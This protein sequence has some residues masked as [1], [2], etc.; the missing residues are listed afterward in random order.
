M[1]RALPFTE[2]SLRRAISAAQKAGLQVT[3]IKP[4][5][6]L[7]TVP[8]GKACASEEDLDLSRSNIAK[9]QDIQA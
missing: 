7:I 1:T 9:W 2:L 5:G 6:T 4:D 3:A 8:V